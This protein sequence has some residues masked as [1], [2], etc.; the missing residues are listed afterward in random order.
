MAKIFRGNDICNFDR[1]RIYALHFQA[2]WSYNHIAQEIGI[3][4]S[5]IA[6]FCKRTGVFNN[7]TTKENNRKNCHGRRKTSARFDRIIVRKCLQDRFKS[8]R[9]I[10]K[11]LSDIQSTISR[12]TI[13][14]RLHEIGV[15]YYV[16]SKKSKLTIADKKRRLIWAKNNVNTDWLAVSFSDESMFQI[17]G[18]GMKYVRRRSGDRYNENC[19]LE[20]PNRS[21][22]KCHV[23]GVFSYNSFSDL[24]HLQGPT[25]SER[26][27]AMLNEHLLNFLLDDNG[28]QIFQ[29]DNAPIHKS[30]HSRKWFDEHGIN[31]MEWPPYSP[32]MNPIENVWGEIKKRLLL[33]AEI[34]NSQ[35]LLDNVRILWNTLMGDDAY[36]QRLIQ[37]MPSRI[38]ALI[39][40]KGSYTKY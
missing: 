14:R 23:W 20:I 31:V 17:G 13:N 27:T 10:S 21:T 15:N 7:A 34:S 35:K 1:G 25:N 3:N 38:N 8:S 40:S 24:A 26:Y 37:S 18:G 19:V 30:I 16:P 33:L 4:K 11:D 2:G 22:G 12:Q 28:I 5:S 32:D 29:Q 39:K 9:R 36:R 6:K